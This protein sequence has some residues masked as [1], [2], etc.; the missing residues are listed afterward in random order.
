MKKDAS[1]NFEQAKVKQGEAQTKRTMFS[2]PESLSNNNEVVQQDT[3]TVE[4][5]IFNN[6]NDQVAPYC[7]SV[8]TLYSFNKTYYV[9]ICSQ[10]ASTRKHNW[11]LFFAKYPDKV[12][13]IRCVDLW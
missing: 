7:S 9:K 11:H 3:E 5:E 8:D 10:K 13:L 1:A 2:I 6:N 12:I 4:Q